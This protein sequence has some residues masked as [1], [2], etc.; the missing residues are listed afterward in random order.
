MENPERFEENN[1]IAD[2]QS[3]YATSG[4]FS[5]SSL[6]TTKLAFSACPIE[7]ASWR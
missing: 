4:G 7:D 3:H 1:E 2:E 5:K 6:E